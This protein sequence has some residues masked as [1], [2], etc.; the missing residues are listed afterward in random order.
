MKSVETYQIL[1][2]YPKMGRGGRAVL[3]WTLVESGGTP[4]PAISFTG[5]AMGNIVT[6]EPGHALN[7]K[8]PSVLSLTVGDERLIA[9]R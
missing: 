5:R 6:S 4:S 9:R 7:P 2:A 8:S 1:H 3:L